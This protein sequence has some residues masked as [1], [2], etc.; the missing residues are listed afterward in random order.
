MTVVIEGS[1]DGSTWV[2]LCTIGS[3]GYAVGSVT[4]APANITT[5]GT[6]LGF[7]DVLHYMRARSVIGGTTPSFTYS[8]T[9]TAYDR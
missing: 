7:C 1:E 4:S 5:T 8:V 2:G 3:N 6:Y 9:A